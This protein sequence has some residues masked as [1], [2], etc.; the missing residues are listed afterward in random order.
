MQNNFILSRTSFDSR[1]NVF[2][3]TTAFDSCG[4]NANS[5]WRKKEH[6]SRSNVPAAAATA[7]ATAAAAA[8]ATTA[9]TAAV[10]AATSA[11]AFSIRSISLREIFRR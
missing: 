5:D 4:T 8:V 9:A 3:F 11:A 7:A 1:Q 2:D 10:V 6:T